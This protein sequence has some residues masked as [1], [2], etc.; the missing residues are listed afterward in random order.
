MRSKKRVRMKEK[1]HIT[2]ILQRIPRAKHLERGKHL[3]LPTH[4]WP[5]HTVQNT[6]TTH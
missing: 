1:N 4:P 5:P 3:L 2:G 6:H